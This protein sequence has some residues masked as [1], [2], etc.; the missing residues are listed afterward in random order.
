MA[1]VAVLKIALQF[2]YLYIC[3]QSFYQK[4]TKINLDRP[5]KPWKIAKR[6]VNY[7]T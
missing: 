2:V 1:L 7:V 5:L 4:V 6:R 3:H